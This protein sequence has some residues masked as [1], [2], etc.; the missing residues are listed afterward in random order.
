MQKHSIMYCVALLC[1]GI[2]G[3]HGWQEVMGLNYYGHTLCARAQDS[4]FVMLRPYDNF[5]LEQ[6]IFFYY[7]QN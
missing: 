4:G 2:E 7:Y 5:S 6:A 3:A 1:G